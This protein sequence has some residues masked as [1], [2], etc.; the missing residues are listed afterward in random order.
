MVPFH[1]EKLMSAAVFDVGVPDVDVLRNW[2]LVLLKNMS[3]QEAQTCALCN[4]D[5]LV[6]ELCCI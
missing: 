3:E 1:C 5:E 4:V 2:S 6:N